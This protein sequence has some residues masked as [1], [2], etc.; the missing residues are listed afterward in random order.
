M[1]SIERLQQH[2]E[3]AGRAE[4]RVSPKELGVTLRQVV[5]DLN[6]PLGTLSMELSSLGLLARQLRTGAGDPERVRALACTMDE[7]QE[8]LRGAQ[9][10]AMAVLQAVGRWSEALSEEDGK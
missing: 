3:R 1:K 6:N 10:T 2:W 5:H 4:D 9:S 7:I 8:N